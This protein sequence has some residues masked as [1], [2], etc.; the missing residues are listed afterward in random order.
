MRAS[1]CKGFIPLQSKH[2]TCQACHCLAKED[3]SEEK[4]NVCPYV[5]P[6][7]H[8]YCLPVKRPAVTCSKVSNP[9]E[10]EESDG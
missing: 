3:V 7:D 4:Q 9:E 8:S 1:S 6:G 10:S 2:V 5:D